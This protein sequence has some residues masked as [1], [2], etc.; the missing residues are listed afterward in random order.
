MS[1]S[2]SS[3]DAAQ[4][5]GDLAGTNLTVNVSGLA[6]GT[7]NQGT[8]NGDGSYTLT[9]AQL[10][11]LTFMPAAEFTGTVN[12]S[13]TATDTEPSSGTSATSAAKTLA[14]TVNP[15][16]EAPSLSSPRRAAT[17]TAPSRFRSMRHR[18]RAISPPRT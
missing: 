11:G 18:S 9:A 10:A 1:G 6:G 16:A 17:R 8:L 13:V 14:A 12:L 15:V 3:I 5:E 4:V 2:V 7:L